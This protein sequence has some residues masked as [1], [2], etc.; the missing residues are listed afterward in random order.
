MRTK[1]NMQGEIDRLNRALGAILA[2]CEAPKAEP[3]AWPRALGQVQA[4][5]SE[6]LGYNVASI[7]GPFHFAGLTEDG[8]PRLTRV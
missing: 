8:I 5:A 4:I 6:A 7:E 3:S 2:A 1:R